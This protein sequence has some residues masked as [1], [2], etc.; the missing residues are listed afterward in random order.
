LLETALLL[1]RSY[2]FLKKYAAHWRLHYAI[3]RQWQGRTGLGLAICRTKRL[4]RRRAELELRGTGDDHP[5]VGLRI[6]R[7]E[8][9]RLKDM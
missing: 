1:Q 2:S 9:Q 8:A 5:T 7:A 6:A 4:P 3:K